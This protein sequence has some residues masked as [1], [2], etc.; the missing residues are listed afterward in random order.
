MRGEVLI[1]IEEFEAL[2]KR[3]AEQG[4]KTYVNARNTASGSLRQLDPSITATRPLTALIYAVVA[5]DGLDAVH[6]VG[7]AFLAAVVWFSG[8]GYG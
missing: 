5:A 6:A 2:N 4:E 7:D 3:L 1:M 8:D